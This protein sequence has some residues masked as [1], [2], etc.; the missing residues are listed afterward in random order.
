MVRRVYNHQ[1]NIIAVQADIA[2]LKEEAIVPP[3]CDDT[4]IECGMHHPT[5]DWY[6]AT[7]RP[8]PQDMDKERR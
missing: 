3:E 7:Q 4:K 6:E 2:P 8:V 5:Y 1:V